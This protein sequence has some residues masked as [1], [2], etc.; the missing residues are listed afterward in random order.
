M[1]SKHDTPGTTAA[2]LCLTMEIEHVYWVRC[3]T[4]TCKRIQSKFYVLDV[5]TRVGGVGRKFTTQTPIT[6]SNL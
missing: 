1:K 3:A 6:F 2:A 5:K 4:F